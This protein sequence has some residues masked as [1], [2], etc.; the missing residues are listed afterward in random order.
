[1][2]LKEIWKFYRA[3]EK[4]RKIY[5]DVDT[6]HLDTEMLNYVK[7]KGNCDGKSIDTILDFMG[8]LT[9]QILSVI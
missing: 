8:K 3:C 7:K 9:C 2:D 6:I 5:H 4:I 1:M